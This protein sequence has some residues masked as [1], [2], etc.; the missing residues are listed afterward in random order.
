MKIFIY[1]LCSISVAICQATLE[2]LESDLEK[3]EKEKEKL[4]AQIRIKENEERVDKVYDRF[5]EY[6]VV[7]KNGVV[8]ERGILKDRQRH[9]LITRFDFSGNILTQSYYEDGYHN[10]V[11]IIYNMNGTVQSL[12]SFDQDTLNGF[13]FLFS[14]DGKPAQAGYYKNN[15][16]HG[17]WIRFWN[18]S[19]KEAI[20]E[21]GIRDIA[22]FRNDTLNGIQTIYST[23]LTGSYD[24]RV[25]NKDGEAVIYNRADLDYAMP[26]NS[27]I[28]YEWENRK[29]KKVRGTKEEYN[30]YNLWN[31]KIE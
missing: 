14:E 20:K 25:M 6:D 29:G 16:K 8:I 22:N 10:G 13:Y 5:V 3:L 7:S 28:I 11:S 26:K 21:H 17:E 9:G 27:I 24:M 30:L 31:D 15:E 2:D 4:Q 23:R 18:P 12:I 19:G 1:F